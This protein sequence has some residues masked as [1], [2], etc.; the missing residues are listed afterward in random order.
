MQ[1]KTRDADVGNG[2]VGT[3]GEGEGGM[4]WETS[5]ETCYEVDAKV[6]AVLDCEF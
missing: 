1:G 4:T 2:L 6:I 5:F 3:A